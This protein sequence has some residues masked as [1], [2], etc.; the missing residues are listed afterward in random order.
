MSAIVLEAVYRV[1]PAE[2]WHALTDS[3]E[4]AD[5]LMPNDFVAEVGHCFTFTTKPRL[6]FDG[7]VRCEVLEIVPERCLR[8]SWAG[9]DQNTVVTWELER[10][11][12]NATR[13]ILRHEGFER[14]TGAWI[15]LVLGRGWKGM[16]RN[17]LRKHIE[18]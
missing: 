3:N 2:V 7:I 1:K 11:S 5:W 12:E 8:Y 10:V 13:L 18:R 4:L 9:A 15:K 14:A 6:N 17:Q 16:M